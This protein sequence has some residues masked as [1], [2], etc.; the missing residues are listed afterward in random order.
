MAGWV[1]PERGKEPREWNPVFIPMTFLRQRSCGP[2]AGPAAPRVG[3]DGCRETGSPR[4]RLRDTR[5]GQAALSPSAH[6]PV[7]LRRPRPRPGTRHSPALL[8][9]KTARV[10]A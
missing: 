3:R 9:E 10:P 4:P 1:V 6:P 5:A 8:G 7:E 2:W